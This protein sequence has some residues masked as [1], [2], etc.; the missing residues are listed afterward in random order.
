MQFCI[1]CQLSAPAWCS[2]C[3][4]LRSSCTTSLRLSS[5]STR[6][7][8]ST[9][10]TA[11]ATT[12]PSGSSSSPSSCTA[13]TSCSSAWPGSS[14]PFRR[15]KSLTPAPELLISCTEQL[16]SFVH[17]P[18]L[19]TT[20]TRSEERFSIGVFWTPASDLFTAESQG[21][22][23][24]LKPLRAFGGVEPGDARVSGEKNI[25]SVNH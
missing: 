3:S 19:H 1:S 18:P 25:Q 15:P 10:L 24:P 4:P 17:L 21:T 20:S 6:A 7:A 8:S 16:F 14:S 9:R 11:R 12:G 2:F 13:S 23:E 5:T 22:F